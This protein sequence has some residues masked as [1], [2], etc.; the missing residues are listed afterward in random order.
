VVFVCQ[1]NQWAIS[2]P[3]DR[4]TAS[5]TLAQKAIAYGMPGVQVDGNDV[6]ACHLA[7]KR[8]RERASA[9]DGPTLIECVTYRLSMHTTADD[10]KRY[11]DEDEVDAWKAKDPVPRLQNF[12]VQREI[13]SE[14]DVRKFEEQADERIEAAWQAAKRAMKE[15]AKRPEQMFDHLYGTRPSYLEKQR[16]AFLEDAR[17]HGNGNRHR[18]D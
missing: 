6:F 11:R 13:V 8:A 2:V 15:Y 3:R 17:R 1:N 10:P 9:G 14:Q 7:A 4:Q 12:L 5:K 18:G 16:M